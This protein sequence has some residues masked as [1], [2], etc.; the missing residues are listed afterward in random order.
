MRIAVVTAHFPP[1]FIS[2]GSLAPQRLAKEMHARGHEV[3]VYA[4]SFDRTRP[5]GQTWDAEDESGFPVRWIEIH[6]WVGWSDANNI[7]NPVVTADYRQWLTRIRPDVVH[8]HSCQAIGVGVVEAAADAG[9]PVV[10]TMHDFWWCCARQFLADRTYRPCMLVVDAGICPCE[11]DHH[12]LGLRNARLR[13]ALERAAVLLCVS[14]SA[15]DVMAANGV[16]PTKLRVDENGLDQVTEIA[17][18]TRASHAGVTFRYTGGWNEMKGARVV[19]EAAR[20]LAAAVPTGWRMI[21]HDL[22]DFLVAND[23]SL[24]GLPVQSVPAFTPDQAAAVWAATDVLLLP[25]IMRESHSLVTREALSAGVPV[26]CTDTLGPEEVVADGV[27]GLV[28]PAADPSSLTEAMRRVV[29]DDALLSAM[30]REATA[31][32]VRA[33]TDQV[34][35]LLDLYGE[36]GQTVPDTTVSSTPKIGRVLFIVG[37]DGAPLRYRAF[38]PAEALSL[39]GVHADVRHYR[40]ASVPELAAHADAIVVYR[41]PATREV[42]EIIGDARRRGVP[43][44]YDVDDL[45]FDPDL[46]SEIPALTI[47]PPDDAALWLE[48]VRRYRTTLEACDA[49]IGS[50]IGLCDHA[51]AVTGLAAFRFANGVGL[52]TGQQSDAA[53]RQDRA[54]GPVRMGYL[55]GTNTHDH[56]WAMIEASVIAALDAHP[57]VELWLVGLVA[58]SAS[59]DRFGD[60]VRRLGFTEWTALPT[61]LRDLD[62]NLAPLTPGSRFNEAKSA[63]K[64]LEAALVG[65]PTVA[66][67]TEPFREAIASGVNGVLASTP[68]G[69]TDELNALLDDEVRRH[70]LGARARRDALLRW[71]PHLQ[72]RT[73]LSILESIQPATRASAWTDVVAPS[74]P[75]VNRPL[76]A[77]ELPL[78]ADELPRRWSMALP[79]PMRMQYRRMRA[80]LW[81]SYRTYRHYGPLGLARRVPGRLR[82]RS[83]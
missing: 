51:N 74:E 18:P 8:V 39:A 28:V 4:G 41:V 15:A 26:I 42:L 70:R 31:V 14:K 61:V 17:P 79:P 62:I 66:S 82:K 52:L 63:I 67:P 49:F 29:A 27:N 50:T 64:C 32:P 54:P 81:R 78:E 77:Y 19:V 47:L 65:T 60:R 7:D 71:S 22:E 43:V 21:A 57:S 36:L 76:E 2:G 58:A 5:A 59:L 35:G 69:W 73:Y 55:S 12:W 9:I 16:D 24:A 34:D 1:N 48:G 83:R 45:I 68:Q 25:S 20:E 53:A 75:Y 40:D 38:L 6:P 72:A 23:V 80:F 44:A 37:I 56:D 10:V 30:R 3:S 33:I 13:D 46:A 11:V